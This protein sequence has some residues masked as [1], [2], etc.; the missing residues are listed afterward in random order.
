VLNRP[1]LTAFALFLATGFA[2]AQPAC[3]PQS[4]F[5]K[6]G[7]DELH[8]ID[9]GYVNN[10]LTLCAYKKD[11]AYAVDK[12]LGCWALNSTTGGLGASAVNSIPGRGRRTELDVQNCIEGYCIAPIRSEEW[13]PFFAVSTDG[14]HTAIVTDALIYIFST[15]TKAKVGEIELR[16][17]GAETNVS[18]APWGVLYH[19]DTLFVIGADA[20]PFIGVWVFKEDGGRAGMIG[21]AAAPNADALNVFNGAYGILRDKVAFADAGLQN[22]IMVT[23]ANARSR[24]IKRLVSYAPCTKKQ[25]DGWTRSDDSNLPEACKRTL[26]AKY[27]PY[28]DISLAQLTSGDIIAALSGPAEGS[29]AVLD[30]NGLTEKRRLKLARCP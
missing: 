28:V 9:V 15:V 17:E 25:F 11:R 2:A 6:S 18:N 5:T 27:Q 16:K 10:V 1:S 26:D 22:L 13:R 12:I 29:I 8:M 24:S 23:G 19:G 14:A 20:G 7:D 30:P 4:V 21:V 3:L